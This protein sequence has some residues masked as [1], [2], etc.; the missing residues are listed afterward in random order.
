[1]IHKNE[2]RP[3]DIIYNIRL[4]ATN[5]RF[6]DHRRDGRTRNVRVVVI[7]LSLFYHV[8]RLQ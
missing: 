3:N 7:V 8:I 2:R 6:I 5:R 1:M 4:Y